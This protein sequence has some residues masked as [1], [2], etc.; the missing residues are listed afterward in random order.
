MREVRRGPRKYYKGR[1][2][3]IFYDETDEIPMYIFN[4]TKEILTFQ[5]KAITNQNVN[6]VNVE[7]YR[8]LKTDTHFTR[9]LTGKLLRVYII[10]L[11]GED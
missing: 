10:D 3:I 8:A 2:F 7:M 6:Q 5:K 4:N 1:Y 9:F 11:K